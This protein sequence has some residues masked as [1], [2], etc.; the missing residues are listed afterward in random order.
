[1]A[2]VGVRRAF[3]RVAVCRPSVPRKDLSRPNRGRNGARRR[4]RGLTRLHH[5]RDCIHRARFPNQ[6]SGC[7]DPGVTAR[8]TWEVL[9]LGGA[10]GTGK[11]RVAYTLAQHLGVGITQVDD[12]YVVLER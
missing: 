6:T 5:A 8:R 3:G 11:T 10:S 4:R 12:L 9:L 7:E 2:R 1:M